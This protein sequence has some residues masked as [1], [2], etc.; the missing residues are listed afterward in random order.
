MLERLVDWIF[1]LIHSVPAL[2]LAEGSPR[3][4]LVRGVLVLLLFVALLTAIAMWPS[5]WAISR[6]WKRRG[7]SGPDPH[8]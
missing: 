4:F 3:F 2:I 5:R 1:S 8:N 6:L 7:N